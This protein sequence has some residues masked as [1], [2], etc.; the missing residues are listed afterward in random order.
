[1]TIV[2]VIITT[3]LSVN[4]VN[5]EIKNHI[6]LTNTAHYCHVYSFKNRNKELKGR[7][8]E[9]IIEISTVHVAAEGLEQKTSETVEKKGKFIPRQYALDKPMKANDSQCLKLVSFSTSN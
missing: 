4:T 3:S 9:L 7:Y 5:G 6:R 1:M 8:I 2:I